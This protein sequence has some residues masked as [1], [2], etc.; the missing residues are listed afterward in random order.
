RQDRR[1]DQA[2]QSYGRQE[3][4]EQGLGTVVLPGG[5]V[6]RRRKAGARMGGQPM[7]T[8]NVMISQRAPGEMGKTRAQGEA[9]RW[10]RVVHRQQ[11]HAEADDTRR[12]CRHRDST[13]E[14]MRAWYVPKT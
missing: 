8:E 2:V 6:K 4:G 7:G 9:E 11:E 1:E 13:V 5:H 3:A 10:P 14:V 12:A